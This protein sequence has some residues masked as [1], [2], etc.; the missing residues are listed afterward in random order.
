[1]FVVT[2]ITICLI[3][4]TK[5]KFCCSTPSL[6][7]SDLKQ[8]WNTPICDTRR[9]F[10]TCCRSI[11][12]TMTVISILG[13]DF[14]I[15]PRKYAKTETF[16]F[17]LMDVGVGF[18][19]F[20]NA[21]VTKTEKI[22]RGGVKKTIL[23][24]FALF[25]LGL[26]RYFSLQEINYQTNIAEYGTHWNFFF[27]LGTI[28]LLSFIILKIFNCTFCTSIF[29]SFT[30]QFLLYIGLQEYVIGDR[31]RENW[32]D[33]NR[34]G[35]VSILGYTSLYLIGIS[36]NKFVLET[37]STLARDL[38]IIIKLVFTSAVLFTTTLYFNNFF[39][40]S[41]RLV[42][43]T[44][45][46]W[47]TS[48][49][50]LHVSVAMVVEIIVI[51]IIT[52]VKGNKFYSFLTPILFESINYNGLIFFLLANLHTGL[53]NIFFDTLKIQTI[54]SLLILVIYMGLNCGIIC[55]LYYRKIQLKFW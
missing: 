4:L 5:S 20:S 54:E 48:L 10:V 22:V 34:E 37:S 18:F 28:K 13:V 17:S 31:G 12:N 16:G 50:L 29:L 44:Y 33:A 21:A 41:R 15:F 47:V 3:F 25:M 11:V 27:T 43:L 9:S 55:F 19:V 6:S 46:S 51:L 36:T 49:A 40:V 45:I 53:V 52:P 39:P 2:I 42:G 24:C 7:S 35:L 14:C 32:I 1:M 38:K 26:S 30:H 23:S 8:I